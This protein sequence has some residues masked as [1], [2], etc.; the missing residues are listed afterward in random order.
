MKKFVFTI[1]LLS[2]ISFA[3]AQNQKEIAAFTESYSQEAKENYSDAIK[4]LETVASV[5]DF[6][7]NLRLGWLYYLK[8][9]QM[10]SLKYYQAALTLQ[11]KS[12]QA[13]FGMAYPLAALKQWDKLAVNYED[14]LKV[15]P[16]NTTALYRLGLMYYNLS[17]FEK[18]DQYLKQLMSVYSFDYS[19]SLLMGWNCIKLGR[20]KD[21]ETWLNVTLCLKP[22]D[23]F[24]L[25][26]MKL[27]KK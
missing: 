15:N 12:I 1:S 7:I 27:L 22:D 9:N 18:A 25:D 16:N 6:G 21:A 13:R 4:A 20:Y 26:G 11:P 24:A 17:N 14:L 3:Q 5:T 19:S 2:V 8:D 23:Q 10:Q